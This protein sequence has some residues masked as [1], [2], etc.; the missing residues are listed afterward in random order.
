MSNENLSVKDAESLGRVDSTVG[1]IASADT[2]IDDIVRSQGEHMDCE[3]LFFVMDYPR[4]MEKI[5]SW[6]PQRSTNLGARPVG[7]H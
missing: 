7:L 2:F 5:R 1:F 6:P 4:S 3:S